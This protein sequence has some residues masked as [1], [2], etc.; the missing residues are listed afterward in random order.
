MSSREEE[1]AHHSELTAIKWPI[2][3]LSPEKYIGHQRGTIQLMPV[4]NTAVTEASRRGT[5]RTPT[6]AGASRYYGS[7]GN[8]M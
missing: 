8:T 1:N 3:H 4:G 7:Q 2:S 6:D 5:S